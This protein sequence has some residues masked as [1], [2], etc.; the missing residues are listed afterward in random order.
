M[1]SDRY[2]LI[3]KQYLPHPGTCAIC[4]SN[5][6]DCVDFRIDI[7]YMGAFLLCTECVGEVVNVD[8]LHLMRKADAVT[9]ME[10]NDLMRRQLNQAVDAMEDMQSGLVATVDT[11]VHRIRNLTSEPVVSVMEPTEEHPAHVGDDIPIKTLG[12]PT[13]S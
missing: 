1:T 7:D 9:L 5:Q 6:R 12:G 8:E 3:A 11:Y 2:V 4:G 10:E 13:F